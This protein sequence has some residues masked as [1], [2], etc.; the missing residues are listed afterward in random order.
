MTVAAGS[1]SKDE[2]KLLLLQALNEPI[3]L[4]LRCS[5]RDRARQKLYA[6]R[7][8]MTAEGDEALMDLQ[9]RFSPVATD[10]LWIVKSKI[11]AASAAGTAGEKAL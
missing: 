2:I 5:D 10:E 6:V 3:G 11:D 4:A 8:E 1:T 9:I 7:K